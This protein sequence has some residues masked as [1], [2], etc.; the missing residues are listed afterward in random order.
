MATIDDV[1]RALG[2]FGAGMQGRGGEY[3][4]QLDQQRQMAMIQDA[5][6]VQESLR[7]Q[8]YE[9]AYRLLNNRVQNIQRLGGDPSD[10]MG[11]IEKMEKG[12]FSGALNDV[13]TVVEYAY[14]SGMLKRPE[15]P[16]QRIVDGQLVTVGK[17][18]KAVATPIEGFVSKSRQPGAEGYQFGASEMLKDSKGNLFTM[19]Q[20]RD[21]ATG[22]VVPSVVSVGGDA[23]QKPVGKL[24]M[25]GGY[26]LTAAE[27][28]GQ[29][30]KEESTKMAAAEGS[31]YL[32]NIKEQGLQA[33]NMMS[34]TQRLLELNRAVSTGSTAKAKRMFAN[35]FNL[36]SEDAANLAEFNQRA[37]QMV[38]ASIRQLG[39]NPT[40]GERAYLEAIQPSI[41]QGNAPNEAMLQ[42]LL[43]I[44]KRQWERGR[45]LAKNPGATIDDLIAYE[46][47]NPFTPAGGE[48]SASDDELI[49]KYLGQ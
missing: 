1:M 42:N 5:T 14:Q 30:G 35:L 44:Q 6:Q 32:N 48:E 10:T 38:L 27:K 11:V 47:S 41:E 17:D 24:E 13:S 20:R 23:N 15:G 39:A 36:E 49:N 19:T 33:R 8:D 25:V 26:G 18:G 2:G 43:D 31:K 21:P 40:E 29:I 22:E 37:G 16:E 9:R 45:W 34:N 12:D 46:E 28:V 4:Q 7:K 3:L